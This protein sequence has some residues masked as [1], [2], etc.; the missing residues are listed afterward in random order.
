MENKE[1]SPSIENSTGFSE[2]CVMSQYYTEI[3]IH[4][5]RAPYTH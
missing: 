3:V 1:E 4:N 2:I 5:E